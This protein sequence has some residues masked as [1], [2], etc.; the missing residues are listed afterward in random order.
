MEVGYY[1]Y[2]IS[3]LPRGRH[4]FTFY[5]KG[6]IVCQ[7]EAVIKEFCT[8]F[9]IVKYL[10]SL[11]RYRFFP[12]NSNWE[13]RITVKQIG[14]KQNIVTSIFNSQSDTSNIGYDTQ[15]VLTLTAENVN[16]DELDK[17]SEIFASPICYLHVGTNDEPQSWIKVIVSGN[18]LN[19]RKKDLLGKVV[20]NVELPKAYAITN[21]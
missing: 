1:R 6:E 15:S 17:L 13:K 21:L 5:N 18:G 12:F 9:K 8:D 14:E 20:I 3:D 16:S 7:H 11:G 2:K 19:R 4:L 10:D